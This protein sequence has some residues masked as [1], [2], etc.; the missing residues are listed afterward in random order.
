MITDNN[1]ELIR[2]NLGEELDISV[3]P[4]KHCFQLV[5]GQIRVLK[6][7]DDS[8]RKT[9][10]LLKEGACWCKYDNTLSF[11]ASIESEVF[12]T[13][14]D[15]NIDIFPTL[16]IKPKERLSSVIQSDFNTLKSFEPKK[17]LSI[18][19]SHFSIKVNENI[20][21]N[22]INEICKI[23]DKKNLVIEKADLNWQQLL[24]TEY[25][26]ILETKDS[27][28]KWITGRKGNSLL[29]D[30][31]NDLER[32]T[33]TQSEFE[34][35]HSIIKIK[36]V[37][38]LKSMPGKEPFTIS[39]YISQIFHHKLMASQMILSSVLIQ[40][41]TLGM[42]IFYMVI[43]DRV[44]G[45]QNIS[46]LN[47]MA[48]GMILI[49]GFDLAVKSLRSFILSNLLESLDKISIKTILNQILKIPQSNITKETYK[50]Y[51]NKFAEL[52][53][54]N[55]T[56][57]YTLL[58]SSL[59][60][61]FSTIVIV[62]LMFLN[63]ELSLITLS[64][65]IPIGIII[66]LISPIQ[67][68]RAA[69]SMK[70]QREG[71]LRLSEIIENSEVIKSVNAEKYI[72][73]K[74][75]NRVDKDI[76]SDFDAKYDRI[77]GGNFIGFVSNLGYLAF[78]YFGAHAVLEGKTSYGIYL[79]ISMLGRNFIGV[80]QKL[81]SS[82]Q[83]FQESLGVIKQLSELSDQEME[84]HSA[85]KL[86]LK[87]VYGKISIRD[88]CFKYKQDLPLIINNA[89]IE[90]E[91]GQK[92]ILTG[93]NGSGKTTLLRLFQKLWI[94]SSGYICLDGINIA[95]IDTSEL[96]SYIGVAFQKPGIF[97]GT[98]KDNLVIGAPYASTESI[99]S[100]C[101]SVELDKYLLDS[102][103]GLDTEILPMG[104][105]IT[106]SQAAQISIARMLLANPDILTID[107]SFSDSEKPLEEAVIT[108][109]FQQYRMKTCIIVTDNIP[110]HKQ[111]DKIMVL[112]N[113]QV[114]E[115]GNYNSLI[116]QK[117]YYYSIYNS[118]SIL[119]I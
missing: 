84:D 46:T 81:L 4:E 71:Q 51:S 109:I 90:I 28:Y 92:I 78:L 83:Q 119:N 48:I 89:N 17:L 15:P 55:Q 33:P 60:V 86:C 18:I 69:E 91:A 30:T 13:S 67:K 113:G 73:D 97:S 118:T 74:T 7:Y 19:L 25:P 50:N 12:I 8:T 54:I 80:I 21:V 2:L 39:W 24:N 37:K 64:P 82:I 38:T 41:F 14:E 108:R 31:G 105:N 20:K 65:L 52:V 70:A 59:D 102:P 87:K 95:E 45:R 36:K 22:N 9:L 32:H 85:E 66:F 57:A 43:F 23:L 11:I 103:K 61:I 99:L 10:S 112:H 114:V 40:F 101:A 94:P 62:G 1:E 5:R 56:F 76:E 75:L 3:L 47:I 96:R 68:K 26:F 44:F 110:I 34:E 6:Q 72:T 58:I 104:I 49:M 116:E 42:P 53:K 93:K 106:R 27:S 98:I 63:W 115:T 29:E 117:G 35:K 88:L 107:K 77:S 16:E 111:A 100:V 79:A